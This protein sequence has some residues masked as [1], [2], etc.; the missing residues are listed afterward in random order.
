VLVQ[1]ILVELSWN[2]LD[3]KFHDDKNLERSYRGYETPNIVTEWVAIL[4]QQ[5]VWI[6][7]GIHLLYTQIPLQ[8]NLKQEHDQNFPHPFQ[9]IIL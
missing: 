6:S 1:I 5:G 9:L 2:L 4:F 8:F 7:E 3:F